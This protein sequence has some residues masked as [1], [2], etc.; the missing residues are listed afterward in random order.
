MLAVVPYDGQMDE[1]TAFHQRQRFTVAGRVRVQDR[2]DYS[3]ILLRFWPADDDEDKDERAFADL[4][5]SGQFSADVEIRPG[6]EG[7]YEF[8]AYLFWPGAPSQYPR[9]RLSVTT[10]TP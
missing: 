2:S 10:V 4:S 9:C 3:R 7:Q 8:D 6:R 5:R 1:A